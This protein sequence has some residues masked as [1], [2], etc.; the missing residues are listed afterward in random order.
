MGSSNGMKAKDYSESKRLQLDPRVTRRDFMNNTLLGAGI[1][2]LHG[3]GPTADRDGQ[4]P[5]QGPGAEWTGPGG[6][7][8][9]ARSNG[10]TWDVME[11]AHRIRDGAH[12][13][14]FSK[15]ADTGERY[16]L[17]IVGGGFAGLAAMHEFKKQHPQ[18][19][20]LLLENHPIFGGYAKA[21]EFVVDG[22]RI[23]GAQASLNFNMPATADDRDKGYW[24][25]FGLPVQ[26]EFASREDGNS[27]IK[28]PKSTSAPLY[29]GEQTAN[30]GYFFQNAQT[31]GQGRWVR[32]IWSDDLQRAPF[33]EAVKGSLLRMRDH[34][35]KGDPDLAEAARLDSMTFS[36]FAARELNLAPEAAPEVLSYITQGIMITGPQI[37]AYGARSLPNLLRF[38]EGSPEAKAADRFISFP[39]GNSV[40]ARS[41][42]KAVI[43]AAIPGP[44]SV[45]AVTTGGVNFA[46]LDRAGAA[47]RIRLKATVVRVKH[48]GDPKTADQVSIVYEQDGR[49]YQVKAKGVVMGIGAWIA[50][51]VVADLP[52]QRRGALDQF[53]FSPMLMVNVALRNWRFLDKL[54]F[55]AARWFDGIGFFGVVRQPMVTGGT[56]APFHPD[57][58]IVMTIY[59]PFPHPELPLEA[60][61]PAGRAELLATSYADYEKQIVGQMV[62]MFGPAGFDARRDIAGIVLNRWG[63][64]F[65]TPP[66]GFFFGKA[67]DSAPVKVVTQPWGRIAFAQTG[68]EGWLGAA[69][70]GKRAVTELAPVF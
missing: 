39:G 18:G 32:D 52:E 40:L 45:L 15:V 43:P 60:Q 33:S 47:A 62:R 2:L 21:N 13:D 68:M 36:D 6:V 11:S 67:G 50:K 63:H 46:A 48:E 57:K 22:H 65:V 70:A 26:F 23:A 20:C 55:G 66:P 38:A 17:V 5:A 1:A 27:A 29:F 14:A 54:G 49:L 7:G 16:D 56:A 42:V 35:L 44:P 9:Y 4:A 10:T 41:F 24:T 61:G 25:E 58:P 19:K 37:S 34:K 28:F 59:V 8:E 53:H 69:H 64:A 31:Q 30:V 12:Q 51:H 3:C